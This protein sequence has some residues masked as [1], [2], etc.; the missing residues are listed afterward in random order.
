LNVSYSYFVSHPNE[1]RHDVRDNF[2]EYITGI[3]TKAGTAE[4]D[5]PIIEQAAGMMDQLA[6]MEAMLGNDRSFA[7]FTKPE[8]PAAPRAAPPPPAYP[9]VEID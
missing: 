8:A 4:D 1:F 3:S 5:R 6:E 2:E 9:T 7:G